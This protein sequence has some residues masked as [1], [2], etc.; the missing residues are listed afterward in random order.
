[1]SM[2]NG[3]VMSTTDMQGPSCR[4]RL[5]AP[6]GEQLAFLAPFHK[7]TSIPFI[8]YRSNTLSCMNAPSCQRT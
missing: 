3:E 5:V 4:H 1:M 2:A 8:S 6:V 7:K